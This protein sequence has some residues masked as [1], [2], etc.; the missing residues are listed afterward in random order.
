MERRSAAVVDAL[1]TLLLPSLILLHLVLAPYS[2]VEESFNLQAAHDIQTYGIPTSDVR[3]RLRADYDHFSFPGVVPRT[4]TGALFLAALSSARIRPGWLRQTVVRGT[5]GLFNTGALLFFRRALSRGLGRD[6]GNWYLV[7]QASQFHVMYYASRTLPNMFAFGLSTIALALLLPSS[8]AA[9]PAHASASAK[10]HRLAF[11]LLAFAAVVFRAELALLI[12]TQAGYLLLRGAAGLRAMMHGLVTGAVLGLATTLA[13]DS[14][15]WQRVPLWPEAAGFHYNAIRGQSAHWGTSPWSFYFANAVPRLLLNP[16]TYLIGIPLA[17]A[18]PGT[19]R[20]SLDLLV[21]AAAFVAVYSAQPH[22]EWRFVV[23]ALPNATATAAVGAS[24]IWRRRR[25]SAGY[26]LLAAALALSVLAAFAASAA[27]LAVSRANYPGAQALARV[28]ALGQQQAVEEAAASASTASGVVLLRRRLHMDPLTCSTGVTRF[29]EERDERG[30]RADNATA[31]AAVVVVWAYDKTE[32][33]DQLRRPA[34]WDQ[35]D[36]V[37]TEAP[38]RVLGRWEVVDAVE[39]WAGVALLRP[40]TAPD[41]VPDGDD[42]ALGAG[43]GRVGAKVQVLS[44]G[45]RWRAWEEGVR[46]YVTRGWW[47]AVRT[48]AR[49]YILQRA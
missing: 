18:T 9:A 16:A 20:P 4:F 6:T 39:G 28:H 35:F 42:A 40:E 23:Y 11:Y 14:F 17:F 36:Y 31:A 25:K 41:V 45:P 19:R 32:D 46:R 2:K 15:F 48:R 27:M 37:L 8:S 33:P 13:L 10:R 38:A 24:W 1:L 7:F 43:G 44:A 30:F 12:A 21:P 34:F 47:L 5:L 22:K 3:A 49:I 26:R 29:L